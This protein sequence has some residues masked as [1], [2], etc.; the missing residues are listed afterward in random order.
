LPPAGLF[1]HTM[2]MKNTGEQGPVERT[3]VSLTP[4]LAR[5]LLYEAKRTG[6][7]ASA[8]VRDALTEY[9]ASEGEAELP[10]FVGMASVGGNLSERVDDL[11]V[12]IMD[13]RFAKKMGRLEQEK[14]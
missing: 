2:S 9:F 12:E 8:V 14:S 5:R 11:M 10:S 4:S 7:P 13:E 6:R 3:T 1:P